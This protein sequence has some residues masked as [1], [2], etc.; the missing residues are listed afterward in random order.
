MVT[1]GNSQDIKR[2]WLST[3]LNLGQFITVIITVGIAVISSL[4]A[5]GNRVT[6]DESR[7]TKLEVAQDYGKRRNDTQ[8]LQIEALRTSVGS[9]QVAI[10]QIS[11]KLDFVN[12]QLSV[13]VAAVDGEKSKRKVDR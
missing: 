1:G 3:N 13:L 2:S 5:A 6:E 11:A 10:G 4:I 8:D 12:S 7:I 9:T